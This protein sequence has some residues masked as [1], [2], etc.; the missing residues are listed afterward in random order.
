MA[1]IIRGALCATVA[2]AGPM[3]MAGTT[4]AQTASAPVAAD[5]PKTA[6][7]AAPANEI[8]E[9]VVTAA[10]RETSI[11]T[12]PTAISS[13]SG[14]KLVESHVQNLGDLVSASPNIQLGTRAS[15]ADVTVRGIGNT[16]LTAGADPGVAFHLDGVYLAQPVLA[17]T[18][19]LDINRVE[20]LRGPQGTLFGRNATGGA[21]NVIPNLPTSEPSYGVDASLGFA[22]TEDQISGFV[23]GPLTSDGKLLGRLAVEQ[24]FNDGFTKNLEPGEPSR[25][26]TT[27]AYGARGQLLWLPTNDFS[28]RLALN[29]QHEQDSGPA[30]FFFGVPD[31]SIPIPAVIRGQ[32]SGSVSDRTTYANEA[33]KHVDAEGATLFTNWDVGGGTLKGTFDVNGTRIFTDTDGDATPVDF[34]A[35]EYRQKAV[36][37]FT[38]LV[39]ASDAALPFTYVV[40]AN[41]FHE[42]EFQNITTPISTL[43]RPVIFNGHLLTDSAAAFAHAQYA[44]SNGIKIFAGFRETYDKKWI[45]ESNNLIGQLTHQASWL[46]PTYEV[47]G[48][49]DFSKSVTGYLKYAVGYKSGGFSSGALKPAFNPE[50][51]Q[52][53]EAGLKGRYLDGALQANLAAFHTNYENLQV[54]QIIG[55]LS[56]VTNAARATIDGIEVET[57]ERIS[58]ALRFEVS[59]GWLDAH[60]NS[61]LTQDSARPSLG[62]LNLAGN[63]LPFAPRFTARAAAYYQIPIQAPGTLTLGGEY[64]WKDVTYFSAFNLPVVSQP[65]VGKVN[66]TLTYESQ[67]RRWAAGLYGRNLTDAVT[68]AAAN[69]GSAILGSIVTGQLDPGREVGLFLHYRP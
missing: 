8:E 61:F 54:S 46:R 35:S 49:Y 24:T 34:A 64:D 7:Q 60:F 14:E 67:D 66:A 1:N 63:Q 56:E 6:P 41:Y 22:P 50:T 2:L 59:G 37:Y 65:S 9:V 44:F 26:D 23:N 36:Q 40:G 13:Y 32:P 52:E 42:D 12:I 25:L 3:M 21:I 38:E 5:A 17:T 53:Y 57:V 30:I 69:A 31:P 33:A 47:G 58:P 51:D 28:A 68:I 62:V 11:R 27:N 15:N 20:I 39:Y 16:L 19:F 29:V 45:D 43:A 4:S 18:N 10:R 55:V 48:S